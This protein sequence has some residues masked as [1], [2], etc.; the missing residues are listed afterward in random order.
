MHGHPGFL[1]AEA[2]MLHPATQ[3]TDTHNQLEAYINRA[4]LSREEQREAQTERAREGRG[5]CCGAGVCACVCV[6]C[7]GQ[8]AERRARDRTGRE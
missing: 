8:R 2:A 7:G 4:G 5:V 6:C 3:H 1:L